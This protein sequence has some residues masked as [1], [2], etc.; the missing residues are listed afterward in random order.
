MILLLFVI[1]LLLAPAPQAVP[2][3]VGANSGKSFA[4]DWSGQY[5]DGTPGAQVTHRA[6][7]EYAAIGQAM[8]A[9]T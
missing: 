1:T 3:D 7:S 2:I 6:L 4:F 9:V 8:A 5:A